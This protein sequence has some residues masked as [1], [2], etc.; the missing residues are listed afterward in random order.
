MKK[1]KSNLIEIEDQCIKI[2]K[3]VTDLEIKEKKT[4]AE[5]LS[6]QKQN[7]AELAEQRIRSEEQTKG[8]ESMRTMMSTDKSQSLDEKD[9][10]VLN[11]QAAREQIAIQNGCVRKILDKVEEDMAS[12]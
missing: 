5:N 12:I 11:R 7:E 6:E 10:M 2:Q 1:Q 3:D 4:Q 8:F 9:T